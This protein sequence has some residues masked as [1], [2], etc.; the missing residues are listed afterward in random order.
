MVS[1]VSLD[2]G[3]AFGTSTT[4]T[5]YLSSG[6][7][8]NLCHADCMF[9]LTAWSDA[10][11]GE[12]IN[13]FWCLRCSDLCTLHGTAEQISIPSDRQPR[14]GPVSARANSADTFDD[15]NRDSFSALAHDKLGG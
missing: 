11:M 8:L 7:S 6:V 9:S 10:C 5:T 14:N 1:R 13:G 3:T 15:R 12:V 4:S 2:A